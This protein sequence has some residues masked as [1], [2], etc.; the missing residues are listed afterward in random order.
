MKLQTKCQ[1]VLAL[2]YSISLTYIRYYA[3]SCTWWYSRKASS[4]DPSLKDRY[5]ANLLFSDQSSRSMASS[6]KVSLST[7]VR[8]QIK[9]FPLNKKHWQVLFVSHIYEKKF[10]KCNNH[11]WTMLITE[12]EFSV[13]VSESNFVVFPISHKVFFRFDVISEWKKW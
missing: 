12:P 7:F 5:L 1:Y 2:L 10:Q 8:A 9:M 11:W 13:K 4:S 6:Y 3:E